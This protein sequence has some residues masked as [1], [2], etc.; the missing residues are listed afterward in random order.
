M[1]WDGA[2][3]S[4]ERDW[5]KPRW[6]CQGFLPAKQQAGA[7]E[8]R[9]GTLVRW[10]WRLSQLT[11]SKLITTISTAIGDFTFRVLCGFLI[12]DDFLMSTSV[13]FTH[14][15]WKWKERRDRAICDCEVFDQCARPCLALRNLRK[16][17]DDSH[18]QVSPRGHSHFYLQWLAMKY[19]ALFCSLCDLQMPFSMNP[20]RERG[21]SNARALHA[22]VDIGC[23]LY[24][25]PGRTPIVTTAPR[26][27]KG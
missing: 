24:R 15:G 4:G 25:F 6:G 13:V 1:L 17:C 22:C 8:T 11:S 10:G 2:I 5:Q 9:T 20:P 7:A 27:C 16:G 23:K 18:W 14:P 21:Q 3:S 12:R 19:V 26:Y